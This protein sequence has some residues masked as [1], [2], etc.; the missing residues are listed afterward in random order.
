MDFA[1]NFQLLVSGLAMGSIYALVALGF[2][3]INNAAGVVNFAQG[4]FVMLPA[5]FA[6]VLLTEFNLGFIPAYILTLV[7]IGIVGYIFERVSILPATKPHV[8]AG[9]DQY[10]RCVYVPEEWCAARLRYGA[11]QPA[12][13]C[14]IRT[15]HDR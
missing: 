15:D 4:E 7:G 12:P 9:R 8:L 10:H 5:F 3:L 1:T 6:A 2:V 13:S 14:P 11:Y